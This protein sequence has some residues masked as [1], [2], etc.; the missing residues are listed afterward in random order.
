[1]RVVRALRVAGVVA[2]FSLTGAVMAQVAETVAPRS[3]VPT[4][5]LAA[6]TRSVSAAFNLHQ[7]SVV[8]LDTAQPRGFA[9]QV[10][11]TIDESIYTLDLQQVSL[12]APNYQLVVQ[13]ADGSL[14]SVE[15][16][17]VRTW[18]GQVLEVEG[19]AVAANWGDDGWR[20]LI[21]FPDRSRYWIEPLT[22]RVAG[23]FAGQHVLYR[24]G[25]V[26]G[27]DAACGVLGESTNDADV[28][29]TGGVA[30]GGLLHIVELA[31][32]S[33]VEY[34]QDY[35]SVQG[36][37]A[38]IHS[39]INTM[40]IQYERDLESRH[41]ISHLIVRTAEP[42]PY[43]ATGIGS[44]LNSFRDLWVG[45][46][47]H[48]QRDA[49]QLFTGRNVDGAFVG[50]AYTNSLCFR[51]AA[52]SVVE[53]NSQACAAFACKTDLSAHELGHIWGANHCE[54]PGWTMNAVLQ[55]A[56]R[57]HPQFDIP[58]IIAIR[59][60]RTCDSLGDK[61]SSEGTVDC[62]DNGVADPCDL[63]AGSSNDADAN[64][65]PDECQPPPQ[66]GTD[67][68][69]YRNRV[70]AIDVPTVAW[71]PLG[72]PT[73]L[74]VRMLTLQEP[75]PPN[76]PGS[77]PPDFSPFES[78]PACTDPAGCV[79]WVGPP[80]E[81]PE[82]QTNPDLGL[83]KIA[84]L[85]CTPFYHDWDAEGLT[86]LVGAELMPSSNYDLENYS[87]RCAGA[88]STCELVSVGSTMTTSR[89]GDV[90]P[91]FDPPSS[92]SQPDALDVVALVDKFKG[93]LGAE[94]RLVTQLQP[95]APDPNAEIN[96]LDIVAGVDAFKGAAYP[97]SGPCVCPSTVPCDLTPCASAAACAG[98][99]CVRTC[100]GGT[101]DAQPCLTDNHCPGGVCGPGFCRDRCA[102]CTP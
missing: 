51:D 93:A 16:G 70:L 59:D 72:T 50:V 1:M 49:A 17:P 92:G 45:S 71:V 61:C 34:F 24:D 6:L 90:V 87:P 82:S 37:E 80:S 68:A 91:P 73:A 74:A 89:F 55:S 56:N 81:F 57:F 98:G 10:P 96:A 3:P 67:S 44:L 35:G 62:N 14:T 43:A 25:D 86:F 78:G 5:D 77:P 97:F 29:D 85:Q 4:V 15:P 94:S 53:S 47:A 30:T 99:T 23:A 54:C 7:S 63:A 11:L 21:H 36:V 75:N 18:R 64:G 8:T 40:N 101:K 66:V 33:D 79:R 102:R 84:R 83:L 60:S 28:A 22:G 58:E 41:I 65:L 2:A 48:I 39:I 13:L 69:P 31:I 46:Y 27:G 9:V 95:N 12:R 42:D 38:Q 100:A 76:A 20:M 88:E 52:F 26:I 19:S 32:D